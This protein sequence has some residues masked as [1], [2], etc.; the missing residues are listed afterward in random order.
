MDEEKYEDNLEDNEIPNNDGKLS[1]KNFSMGLLLVLLAVLVGSAIAVGAGRKVTEKIELEQSSIVTTPIDTT[2][3]KAEEVTKEAAAEVT[4]VPDERT[5]AD[6][7]DVTGEKYIFPI[8]NNIIKDYSNG[9]AVKSNTLGDWR[10][11]NGIDFTAGENEIVKAVKSGT[12]KS[13]YYDE[14]WGLIVE[15]DHGNSVIAKYCGLKSGTT[16]KVGDILEQGETV[17]TVGSIPCEAA[18]ETHLHFEMSVAG[19]TE[20]PIEIMGIGG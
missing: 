11:H 16:A 4:G 5:A 3:P 6:R 12:V 13:V 20:D 9:V 8:S 1:G 17:G 18:D 2:R 10:T 19:K 7:S 14:L 15:I